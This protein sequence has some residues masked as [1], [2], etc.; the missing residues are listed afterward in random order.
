MLEYPG[1]AESSVDPVYDSKRLP[2][3]LSTVVGSGIQ[4]IEDG[5]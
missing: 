2:L 3:E 5:S 1:T 4:A